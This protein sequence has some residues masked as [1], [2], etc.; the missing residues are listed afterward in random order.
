MTEIDILLYFLIG[1]LPCKIWLLFYLRQ[2]VQPESNKKIIEIFLL[3]AIAVLP[4]KLIEDYLGG[5]FPE[6]NFLLKNIPLLFFYYIVIIGFTEE[7]FKYLVVRLRVIKSSHFDEP[8][9]AM[10]YMVIVSLGLAAVENVSLI[11]QEVKETPAI[12]T[13]I[14][15]SILRFLTAIFLHTLAAAITGY[16]LACSLRELKKIK[17]FFIISL[18]LAIASISHGIYN[19]S[20]VKL[21]EAQNIFYFFLPIAIIFIMGIFVYILFSKVKKMPRSC[22]I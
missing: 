1:I 16:F 14:I 22:N 6:E 15:L 13:A 7:F 4:I 12:Q 10:L 9:D 20:I 18:G 5:F 2:D 17:K 8:I 3:G 19:I 21:I 11:I